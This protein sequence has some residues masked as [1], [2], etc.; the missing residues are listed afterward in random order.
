[1]WKFGVI[2]P[3]VNG[4]AN[5]FDDLSSFNS[6]IPNYNITC[7]FL[8]DGDLLSRVYDPTLE[9]FLLGFASS[10]ESHDQYPRININIGS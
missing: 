3:R 8:H 7:R 1:M 5:P 4:A 10:H 2:R 9:N 6:M